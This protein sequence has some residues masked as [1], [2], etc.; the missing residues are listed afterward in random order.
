MRNAALQLYSETFK[1]LR[2]ALVCNMKDFINNLVINYINSVEV[3]CWK[4]MKKFSFTK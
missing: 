2:S 4:I 3:E 1:A